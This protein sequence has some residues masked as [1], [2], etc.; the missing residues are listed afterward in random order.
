MPKIIAKEDLLFDTS[1]SQAN[2]IF[3]QNGVE[4]ITLTKDGMTSPNFIVTNFTADTINATNVN[5]NYGNIPNIISNN[6]TNSTYIKTG[7]LQTLSFSSA[8]STNNIAIT[9][10]SIALAD[11]SNNATLSASKLNIIGANVTNLTTTGIKSVSINV[12]D[13]NGNTSI[14]STSINTSYGNINK[15]DSDSQ[16]NVINDNGDAKAL[17]D[18]A[19]IN[20]Q[21]NARNVNV[22]NNLVVNYDTTLTKSVKLNNDNGSITIVSPEGVDSTDNQLINL[23]RNVEKELNLRG[24]YYISV[25]SDYNANVSNVIFADTSNASFTFTL[26]S[27]PNL[28]DKIVIIDDKGTFDSNPLTVDGNGNT[29]EGDDTLKDDVKNNELVL[30]FANSEW[31]VL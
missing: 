12:L 10:T 9:P 22:G 20:Y 6:I 7:S 18:N 29:I 21:L 2:I 30:V 14:T 8:D 3:K 27:S 23:P 26:P 24:E 15:I 16:I 4:Y 28:G 19:T 5:S 17:I 1:D 31:K 13:S 11:S 25:D